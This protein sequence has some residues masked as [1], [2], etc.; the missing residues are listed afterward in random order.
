[1]AL[2]FTVLGSEV[3]AGMPVTFARD[4]VVATT[5]T[6]PGQATPDPCI[7]DVTTL[8]NGDVQV[9]LLTSHASQWQ[10][11]TPAQGSIAALCPAG[12]ASPFTD[13]SADVHAPAVSCLYRAGIVKGTTASSYSPADT[14][15]REE[16]ASFLSRLLANAGVALPNR[17]ANPFT[18]VPDGDVHATAIAQLAAVGV[19]H[20]VSTSSYRPT[21]V[22]SRGQMAAFLARAEQLARGAQLPVATTRFAD[23]AGDPFAE[24]IGRISGVG[25]AAGVTA[26]EYVPSAPVR[27]NQMASFLARTLN[28]LVVAGKAPAVH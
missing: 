16:M 8:P 14:V 10:A 11:V 22:V 1:M 7:A 17:P 19:V 3:P 26:T 12:T 13:I 9:R 28:L 6:T 15:T 2:T 24:D 20:G 23:I 4:G 5:C 18:D 25:I 21:A 27:R